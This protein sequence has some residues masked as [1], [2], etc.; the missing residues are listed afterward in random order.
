MRTPHNANGALQDPGGI[1]AEVATVAMT[2]TLEMFR[3]MSSPREQMTPTVYLHRNGH[4]ERMPL[5]IHDIERRRDWV[6]GS[7]LPLLVTAGG[8]EVLAIAH[9]GH[10]C[11]PVRREATYLDVFSVD[12]HEQWHAGVYRDQVHPPRLGSWRPG[13]TGALSARTVD[14]IGGALTHAASQTS[15]PVAA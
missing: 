8:V 7:L 13:A 5:C 14:A 10:T 11:P 6:L 9:S 4:L 1:L 12:R 3:E 15:R 2:S